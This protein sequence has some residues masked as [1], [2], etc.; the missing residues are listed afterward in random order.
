[1]NPVPGQSGAGTVNIDTGIAVVN[2]GLTTANVTYTLRDPTGNTLS[3]GHGT[4]AAGNHF[5]R[6]IDQLN[7]V[8][9]DF[10]LPANFQNTTQFGTLEID[11]DQPLSVLALRGTNN[12]R[13]EFLMTTTPT[14]DL[15]QP[16][17]YD[18]VYFAQ[19]ADGGGYT[20]SVILVNTSDTT[21][22]G[23]LQ[24]LDNNGNPLV[25]NQVGGTTNSSFRYSIPSGG[26]FHFQTDGSPATTNVGW[27]QLTPDFLNPTPIGSGVFSYNPGS[28]LVSE[29]GIP[30]AV[31]TT[32]ARVFV[33]LSGNHDTGLAIANVNSAAASITINAY[34]NDGVTSVG[35]SQGPLQLVGNGHASEFADQFIAAL[36]SGFNGVLDISSTT[37]F[38]ALT[39]RSLYNERHDFLMTTFPVA[40]A[41]QAAPS[42][43]VF[44]QVADGGGY[45]TQFILLSAV[46]ASSATV[47]FFDETGAP[48][49]F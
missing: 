27:V 12:Q 2:Y 48:I 14:A 21:E 47:Q 36:P 49:E 29:S 43:I 39:L 6:F 45:R 18:P 25:A 26:A 3:V 37:P 5:A 32:H 40:D 19:F 42:P 46:G 17:S 4:I 22:T 28:T 20:T 41:N 30:A 8:A 24:I 11:S 10:N 1:V 23:T 16:F 31:P 33:D 15:A 9:P 34:Q 7:Q 13:N 35:T 44:P 38:A